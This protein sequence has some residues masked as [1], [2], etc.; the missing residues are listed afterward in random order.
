M[1][2]RGR[3]IIPGDKGISHRALLLSSISQ[4]KSVI[5]GLNRGSDCAKTINCLQKLGVPIVQDGE[6]WSVFGRGF[7]LSQSNDVLDCGN[8]GRRT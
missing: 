5:S 3:A 1:R 7:Q 6:I 4:G 8:S 2:L